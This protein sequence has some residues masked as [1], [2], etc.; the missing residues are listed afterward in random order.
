MVTFSVTQPNTWGL[1]NSPYRFVYN[2]IGNSASVT[3]LRFLGKINRIID[4]TTV[5]RITLTTTQSVVAELS[6]PVRPD[7]KGIVDCQLMKSK[8]TQVINPQ[9]LFE[10]RLTNYL[11]FNVGFGFECNPGITFS[12]TVN[13][14]N[15]VGLTGISGGTSSFRVNDYI[16][17]ELDY[18]FT[19]P[20]YDGYATISSFSGSS[21]VTTIDW[22]LTSS[23]T[24]SGSIYSLRRYT[25]TSSDKYLVEGA[26]QYNNRAFDLSDDYV[27][28][29]SGWSSKNY[30]TGYPNNYT[31]SSNSK[32]SFIDLDNQSGQYETIFL[33]TDKL[34]DFND[35]VVNMYNSSGNVT[36]T[37]SLNVWGLYPTA[38]DTLIGVPPGATSSSNSWKMFEVGIGPQQVYLYATINNLEPPTFDQV[39][40]NVKW[41][42]IRF[43]NQI[44]N[45]SRSIFRQVTCNSSVYDNKQ[46]A[47]KNRLGGWDYINFD[48]KNTRTTTSEKSSYKRSLDPSIN[49]YTGSNLRQETTINVKFE[50]TYQVSTD[51]MLESEYNYL[52]ELITSEDVYL[53]EGFTLTPITIIDTDFLYKSYQNGDLFI[54]N[55]TYKFSFDQLA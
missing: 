41:Y 52:Q 2:L 48:Q 33:L 27:W 49:L 19:N 47:F 9:N 23:V 43:T 25:G 12:N 3:N 42:S 14:G 34:G 5:D 37:Y 54:M 39:F 30:L 13:I 24:Q 46:I 51:W 22:G 4:T 10:D 11:R 15:K 17:I 44:G 7:G 29:Q 26:V 31:L 38:L 45:N 36:A 8:F 20:N 28:R 21:L 1:S 18:K 35:I 6:A 50:E 16:A 53:V 55:M 40:N 32:K